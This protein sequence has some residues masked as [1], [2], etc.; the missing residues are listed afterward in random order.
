MA[1]KFGKIGEGLKRGTRELSELEPGDIV[2]IQNQK[3]KNP[4]RWDKSGT[5]IERGGFGQ[6]SVRMDGSGRVT[7]RNRKYLRKIIPRFAGSVGS[8]LQDDGLDMVRQRI[9]KKPDRFQSQW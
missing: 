4:L 9:R 2:Q 1:V 6:Y 3:G 5:V 8:E 7:L